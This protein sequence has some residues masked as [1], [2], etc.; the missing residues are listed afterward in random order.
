MIWL[1]VFFGVTSLA[2]FINALLLAS[3]RVSPGRSVGY[4]ARASACSG[5]GYGLVVVG[6]ALDASGAAVW[7]IALIAGCLVA[8][9]MRMQSRARSCHVAS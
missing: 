7:A 6:H 8:G 4:S 9:A 2:Y 5:A 1:Y 3:G